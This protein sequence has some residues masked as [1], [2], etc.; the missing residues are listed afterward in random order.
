[1]VN[2]RGS[3]GQPMLSAYERR[4]AALRANAAAAAVTLPFVPA[5]AQR[6]ASASG[7]IDDLILRRGASP[8]IP[9]ADRGFVPP[10]ATVAANQGGVPPVRTVSPLAAYLKANLATMK[11]H[12]DYAQSIPRAVDAILEEAPE[13]GIVFLLDDK[14]QILGHIEA[15]KENGVA[16]KGKYVY[17]PVD[18]A[19][20]DEVP[21]SLDLSRPVSVR[22]AALRPSL[23]AEPVLIGPIRPAQRPAR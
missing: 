6:L 4:L 1:V 14:E 7:R 16:I 23:A 20:V 10:R 17:L 8:R 13:E 15:H 19:G 22:S 3:E 9:V 5:A 21:F 18:H 11:Q 2:H 12:P